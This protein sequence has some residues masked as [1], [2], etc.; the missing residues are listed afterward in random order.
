M[1][2]LASG[3]GRKVVLYRSRESLQ[4]R[5]GRVHASHSS[6]SDAR[7]RRRGGFETNVRFGLRETGRG[8]ADGTAAQDTGSSCI[9]PARRLIVYAGYGF[10][11]VQAVR[12]DAAE[13][14]GGKRRDRQC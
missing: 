12:G 7:K 2:L 4:L 6:P 14:S 8:S 5:R 11:R 10:V 1:Q 3:R 13:R 9:C